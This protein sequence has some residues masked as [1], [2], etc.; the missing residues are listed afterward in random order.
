MSDITDPFVVELIEK[1]L[2]VTRQRNMAISL[3]DEVTE[4]SMGGT[5][6]LFYPERGWEEHS[7]LSDKLIVSVNG[8]WVPKHK[9]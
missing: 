9:R 6:D 3:L 5:P 8:P 4:A 1:L 7:M 2:K